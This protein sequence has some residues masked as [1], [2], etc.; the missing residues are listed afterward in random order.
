VT[1]APG[2]V[3]TVVVPLDGSALAWPA[4]RVA[5]GLSRVLGA[6][7]HLVSAVP[8]EHDV[9]ERDAELAIAALDLPRRP[10]ARSV[11]VD[12]D[13]AEAIIRT[14]VRAGGHM[15]CM[16]SHGR[17][18]SVGSIGSVAEAVAARS[19]FPVV[20]MCS[21]VDPRPRGRGVV[22]CVDGGPTSAQ[23]VSAA[24]GWADRLGEPPV[25]VTVA[26][27]LEELVA[28]FRSAGRDVATLALQDPLDPWDAFYH[29]L[30]AHPA[31]LVVAYGSVAAA[32]VRHSPSPVLMT[33][34]EG[35]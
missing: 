16:A 22:A 33:R 3:G 9:E 18:R 17:G 13:P 2:G 7:V 10:I 5:A 15:V 20:L 30:I 28:P 35:G 23:V 26:G 4:L 31:R 1:A 6:G 21:L 12:P 19:R 14:G 29:H 25:V 27:A 24:L 32:I 8:S 11:V 34:R